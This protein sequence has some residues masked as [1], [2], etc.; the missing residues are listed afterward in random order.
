MTIYDAIGLTAPAMFLYAYL[1]VSIGKWTSKMAR[2][3]LLNLLGAIT[4]LVSLSYNF[5]LPT[6]ILEV[7]W[8]AI[9]IYGMVKAAKLKRA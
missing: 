7:I 2:F 6:T 8:G 3:H 9:S 4:M 1:M 5:N